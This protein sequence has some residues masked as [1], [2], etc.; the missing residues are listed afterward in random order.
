MAALPPRRTFRAQKGVRQR[1]AE[2]QAQRV[3]PPPVFYLGG[4]GLGYR[5]GRDSKNWRRQYRDLHGLSP[6]RF[7]LAPRRGLLYGHRR[8]DRRVAKKDSL[9]QL[10]AVVWNQLSALR[11]LE[12]F[13]GKSGIMEYW[14][15]S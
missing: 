14:N 3:L 11:R 4:C 9:G 10:R 8:F 7:A 1:A 15:I 13:E 12:D 6:R 5:R 2:P